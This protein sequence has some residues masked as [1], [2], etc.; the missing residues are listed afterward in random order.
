MFVFL[1]SRFVRASAAKVSVFD[2]GFQHGEGLFETLLVKQGE[3][4]LITPH[5]KRLRAGARVLGM[6]VPLADVDLRKVIT[7]LIVK[8]KMKTGMLRITLTPETLLL[9]TRL[10]P[11]R[12]ATAAVAFVPMERVLPQLKSLNYLPSVLAQRIATAGGFDEALLVNRDGFV[13]EGARTNL[14]WVK[15]GTVFTPDLGSALSG[16]TRGKVIE[17][18]KKLGL[19]CTEKQVKAAELTMADEIFLTNAPME[20]WPVTKLEK[21]RLKVGQVTQQ[22]RAAYQKKYA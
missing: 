19:K 22:I 3:A 16:I 11:K 8:N 10:I 18:I 1:N 17:I 12:P 9:T 21:R 13:T 14:F 6:R 7:K 5:L 20:I 2:P 15:R 4:E